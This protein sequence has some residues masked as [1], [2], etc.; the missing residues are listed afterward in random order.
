[1]Q[2]VSRVIISNENKQVLL[3]KRS[4]GIEKGKWSI[5]GG[6]PDENESIEQSAIREI[7]EET[8]LNLLSVTFL[9]SD[10]FN[11]WISYYFEAII[12]RQTTWDLTEHSEVQFFSWDDL[13]K[14]ENEIAFNHYLVLKRYFKL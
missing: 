12:Q 5:L 8:G 2:Q 1:M 6:K 4:S 10:H 14:M 13:Q 11:D 3:G 9:F 7:S